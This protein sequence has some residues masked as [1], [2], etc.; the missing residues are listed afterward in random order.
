[1]GASFFFFYL[2]ATSLPGVIPAWHSI[3]MRED[4]QYLGKLYHTISRKKYGQSRSMKL[5]SSAGE[6]LWAVELRE[7]TG[8]RKEETGRSKISFAENNNRPDEQP[9]RIANQLLLDW[10]QSNDVYLSERS[11]WMEAPHPLGLLSETFD[12][13]ND[14]EAS[15]RGLIAR[16]SINDGDCLLDI[17]LSLCLTKAQARR[18]LGYNVVPT[19]TSEYIAIALLIMHET[20]MSKNESFWWPYLNILP[21]TEEVGPSFTWTDEE[22]ALLEGSPA[23]V[24]T[25]SLQEKLRAEYIALTDHGG[26][27]ANNIEMFPGVDW[28]PLS[29]PYSIQRGNISNTC[30]GPFSFRNFLWAFTIL[31]SRAIRLDGL[32]GGDM[33]A[34][35]PYA[36]L[37][38]HSPFST[39]YIQAQLGKKSIFG[40]EQDKIVVFADRTFKKMEQIFVSYGQKSN[41]ELL[42]LYGFSLDRNPFNAVEISI[43]LTQDKDDDPDGSLYAEKVCNVIC[44]WLLT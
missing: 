23:L 2:V 41:A 7:A 17:P 22:L 30:T 39:A 29:S 8:S 44:P 27:F 1:M 6:D 43:R 37:I 38:N 31:F 34:L 18:I 42:L 28:S 11:S 19:S 33:I 26:I 16:R 24:A 40:D 14:N 13:N 9:K 12:E 20:F 36:D 21:T 35:V 25:R 15:G 5:L 10:L 32:S 3:Y 4:K